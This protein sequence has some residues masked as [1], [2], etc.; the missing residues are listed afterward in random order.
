MWFLLKMALGPALR[1]GELIV[2]ARADVAKAQTDQE[3]T[4]AQERVKTLEARRDVLVAES[5]S[6]INAVIRASFALPFVIYNAKLVLW[7]KVLGWGVTDPL[8]TE[9][10]QIELAC[11]SFYFLYDI[12][13]RFRR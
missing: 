2:Q 8:S 1:I 3:R 5:R 7:D 13:G 9:L 11:I 10:F 4:R 6:P 12:A